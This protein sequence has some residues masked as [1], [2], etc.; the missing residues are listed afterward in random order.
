MRHVAPTLAERMA[1]LESGAISASQWLDDILGQAVEPS[2][3]SV[4]TQLF[5][6][7]ARAE[8]QA[9]DVTRNAGV[10]VGPLAGLPVAIKDLFDVTGQVTRAGSRLFSERPPAESD[11]ETVRRLRRAGAVLV[12]H[13]NMT[14]FAYSG[15]GLNPHY[16][17]PLN[18][19]DE[20]RIPGGSSSGSAAAVARGL[21]A[22]GLATD[23]GGSV[24]IPAAF[25]GLVGFKP[26]QARI[27][28]EGAFPLSTTLDSIGPIAPSVDCCARLDD[29]LS[30]QAV[31]PVSPAAVRGLRLAVPENYVLED[32]DTVVSQAVDR[33]FHKLSAAGA[34]IERTRF[35]VL[36]HVSELGR[37]GGFS[38]AES[39]HL[40]RT[41]LADHHD[42]YDP[43]VVARIEQGRTMTAAEYLDLC[44]N[45][46]SLIASMDRLMMDWD[47]LAMPTVAV[48]PPRFSELEDD[49]EYMRINRLVLRNAS[50]ANLLGLCAITLPCHQA[51]ELPVGL[52]LLGRAGSDRQLLQ[53]ALGVEARLNTVD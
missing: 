27:P 17:T 46:A 47:V 37:G 40:H 51:G 35:D 12:G 3:R 4:Y 53:I 15:L 28:R 31:V 19:L 32:M 14:E 42:M 41:W 21:A 20:T 11:A 33:A 38:A 30:G 50:I 43:R 23:T 7:T 18:P 45:Q 9:I 1:A 29:V 34:S 16:G 8:A 49:E 2:A 5:E 24:R 39:Y 44:A 10:P 22:A 6:Q 25:C 26:T 36:D 13:A 48:V 52:M